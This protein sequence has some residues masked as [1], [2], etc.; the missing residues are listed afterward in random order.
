MVRRI[1]F[2]CGIA[3]A[4]VYIAAVVVGGILRPDYNHLSMAISGLITPGAANKQLLDILFIVASALLLVFAWTAG[5][6]VRGDGK[7]IAVSGAVLLAVAALAW[8]AVPLFPETT[9]GTFHLVLAGVFSLAAILSI[10]FLALGMKDRDAFWAYSM[11]SGI[12][13]LVSAALAAAA[14][15][16]SSPLMGLA[17]RITIGL[18]LQWIILFSGRFVKEDLGR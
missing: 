18:F 5:M 10:F 11:V 9:T 12:L 15:L 16:Q 4:L 6:G 1:F 17:E 2:L 13:V 3:A 8:L 14:A 7:G